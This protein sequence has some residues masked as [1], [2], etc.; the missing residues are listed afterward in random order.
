MLVLA[1][2]LLLVGSLVG[3]SKPQEQPAGGDGP[4]AAT[5]GDTIKIGAILPLSG[6]AAPVGKDS[7]QGME[8]AVEVINGKYPEIKDIP[9]AEEEGIPGLGGKKLEIMFADHQAQPEKRHG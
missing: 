3:C 5:E 1:L 7:R 6:A 8:F 4:A 2:V 9:L